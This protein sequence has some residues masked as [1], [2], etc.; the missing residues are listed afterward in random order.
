MVFFNLTYAGVPLLSTSA[1]AIR[2]P[3]SAQPIG[4]SNELSFTN[5]QQVEPELVSE[6]NRLLELGII[7]DNSYPSNYPGRNLSALA[8]QWPIHQWPQFPVR[9]G[10]WYYPHGI[11]RWSVFRGLATSSMVQAILSITGGQSP[12]PFVMQSAPISPDNPTGDPTLYTLT[13]DMH[14]L[15]ARPLAEHGGRFDGLYIITLVDIRYYFQGV[16]STLAPLL[17]NS[18][19]WT[20]LANQLVDDLGITISF[21]V[22]SVYGQPEIDSQLW[23]NDQNSAFLLDCVAANVGLTIVRNLDGSYAALTADQSSA[24]VSTNRG[25]PLNVVRLAGGNIFGNENALAGDL[26]AQRNQVLPQ[27]VVVTYPKY[28]MTADPVP[29]FVNPR[30]G[31]FRPSS[32][33]EDSYGDTWFVSIPLLSGGLGSIISG[34]AGP[35]LT[36]TTGYIPVIHDTAKAL[37]ASEA[38]AASG[39]LPLNVSGLT[40]LATQLAYNVYTGLIDAALDE[41][42]PGIFAW[43]PEGIHDLLWSYSDRRRLAATRVFRPPWNQFVSDMQHGTFFVSGYVGT[44]G[45]G[46]HSVAQAWRDSYSGNVSTT[47]SQTLNSGDFTVHLTDQSYFPT[48]NR[49]YYKIE[50]EVL[51]MEGT[52]GGTAVGVVQRGAVGTAQVSHGNGTA[53]HLTIPENSFGVNLV[54]YEKSQFIYPSDWKSGGIQGVN[55]IP[56]LQIVQILYSG[57]TTINGQTVYSGQVNTI[58]TTQTGGAQYIPQ[59]LV[60]AMG[61]SGSATSGGL[62]MSGYYS[63][64]FVGYSAKTPAAAPVYKIIT[65]P[66]GGAGPAATATLL[67]LVAASGQTNL[68]SGTI[69]DSGCTHLLT[70]DRGALTFSGAGSGYTH[71]NIVDA[72]V[73]QVGALSS[74][75]QYIGGDKSFI[76]NVSIM[77]SILTIQKASG[78]FPA[79]EIYEDSVHQT[80]RFD[81]YN[82]SNLTKGNLSVNTTPSPPTFQ[83]N[84]NGVLGGDWQMGNISSVPGSGYPAMISRTGRPASGFQPPSF[85]GGYSPFAWDST[86]HQLVVLDPNGIWYGWVFSG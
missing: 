48:Q 22:D 64:Q 9:I 83:F 17:N 69:V 82:A 67:Q 81:I 85:G 33:Y 50:D 40:A 42:Y 11:S 70:D 54:T 3:S 61:A 49:T 56:Q 28:V 71:I 52:S 77:G 10:D 58:D 47:L 51:L 8:N 53:V 44:P 43:Q 57:T 75:T 31:N 41:V 12:S 35:G 72:D 73:S 68:K 25:S 38:L 24:L 14:M 60:W 59:E 6:I 4:E 29:H 32:W 78:F 5:R 63:A 37:Y 84:A 65:G 15:N 1:Q 80:I 23:T 7:Q 2:L 30:Y 46:G 79:V 19:T 13:T 74:G 18:T 62:V 21:S 45:V 34:F 55:V 39:Q 16:N 20:Q 76:G 27:S 36:G 66:Q 86:N 26:N